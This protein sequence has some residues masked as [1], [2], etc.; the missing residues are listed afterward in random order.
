MIEFPMKN[1]HWEEIG[2][3]KVLQPLFEQLVGITES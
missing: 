1:T 2:M 3:E